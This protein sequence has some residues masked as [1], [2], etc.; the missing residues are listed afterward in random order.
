MRNFR[1][2]IIIG[3]SSLSLLVMMALS[4]PYS[5][6]AQDVDVGTPPVVLTPGAPIRGALPNATLPFTDCIT[7]LN[8]LPG[9]QIA[10][11]PGVNIRRSADFSSPIVWNTSQQ[12][13]DNEGNR[14][15]PEDEF[16]VIAFVVEGPVCA[17]GYN[18]WR[19]NVSGGND[20]W[21]AE[22]RPTDVGGYLI[23]TGAVP[24]N[25]DCTPA[26][27][28]EVGE[29]ALVTQN[30]RVRSEPN[31]DG[32]VVTVAPFGSNVLILSEP[33]CDPRDPIIWFRVQV[34]VVDFVYTGWMSQG[35]GGAIWL[36]PTDLPSE[37]A[38]TLC[39][40][41][42]DFA[43]GTLGYVNSFEQRPRYLRDAPGLDS[44]VKFLLVDGVPFEFI[45][46]PICADNINYWQIR[47]LSSTYD[48]DGWIA[49]GSR[50]VGYWLSPTDPDEYER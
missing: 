36:I 21:V 38:G 43:I 4:V 50:G 8:L 27:D 33:N 32:R 41:P 42:L 11:E 15:L 5:A 49:E 20:G 45:G 14:L 26:F 35:L 24:I 34:E 2:L 10:I 18:W 12:Q 6:T 7:P 46:G 17:N 39:G 22:G 30:V 13:V 29:V 9:D 28:L 3:L 44:N 31:R 19:V 47:V 23:L 37:E 16:N 25:T 48:V 40:P 1:L